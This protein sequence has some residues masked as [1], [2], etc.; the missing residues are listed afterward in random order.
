MH[1][2]NERSYRLESLRLE[3]RKLKTSIRG[4]RLSTRDISKLPD[5]LPATQL[6]SFRR[7]AL[8]FPSFQPVGFRAF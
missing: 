5:Y 8:S 4:E 2:L 6:P 3:A 7:Q 1:V